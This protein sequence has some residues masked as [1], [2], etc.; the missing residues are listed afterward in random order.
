MT[1]AEFNLAEKS[2][3]ER[4]LSAPVYTMPNGR[5]SHDVA[6]EVLNAA[7]D[8]MIEENPVTVYGRWTSQPSRGDHVRDH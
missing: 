7:I 3:A 4:I 1:K 6:Y 2:W 8:R 5:P